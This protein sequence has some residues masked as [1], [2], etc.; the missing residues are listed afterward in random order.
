MRAFKIDS[1]SKFQICN[2][3]LT[4]VSMLYSTCPWL[5]NWKFVPFDSL[6][7]F[8]LLPTPHLWQTLICS[9]YL[10]AYFFCFFFKKIPYIGEIIWYLSFSI[11]L[12]SLSVIQPCCQ[13]WQDLIFYGW[14]IF[15]CIYMCHIFFIYSSIDG[16]LG[17]F[18]M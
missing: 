10:W 17:C 1:F 9:L 12:I 15:H 3:V 13:K 14:I 11:W 6:H 18:H 5:Y 16:H 8:C 2:T 7:L 4:I